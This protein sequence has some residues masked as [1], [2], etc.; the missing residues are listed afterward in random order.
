MRY[1]FVAI[2]ASFSAVAS[3]YYLI[4]PLTSGASTVVDL[5]PKIKI[6]DVLTVANTINAGMPIAAT[7][8]ASVKLLQDSLSEAFL[9][10]DEQTRDSL[11]GR[12]ARVEIA[13]GLPLT[14]ALLSETGEI[15]HLSTRVSAGMRAISVPV[16]SATGL[17]GLLQPGDRVDVVL[18][19]NLAGLEAERRTVVSET[20]LRSVKV[21]A[22]GDRLTPSTAEDEDDGGSLQTA[23]LEVNPKD[24][25]KLIVALQIGALSLLL[26]PPGG[27]SLVDVP[28]GNGLDE[29]PAT[30]QADVSRFYALDQNSLSH[31]VEVIRGR[32]QSPTGEE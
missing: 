24:A 13:K 19:T 17:N 32:Q 25:E 30:T 31:S 15:G 5:Q 23:T 9:A 11:I 27:S 10:A 12:I 20:M 7:D 22:V 14:L 16:D 26:T 3:G 1:A 28:A 29:G 4:A 18:T 21:I 8:L 2:A 6:V